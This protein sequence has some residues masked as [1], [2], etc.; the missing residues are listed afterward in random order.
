MKK[1]SA[2]IPAPITRPGPKVVPLQHVQAAG[3]RGIEDFI[4]ELGPRNQVR[5]ELGI[6]HPTLLKRLQSPGTFTADEIYRLAHI[7]GSPATAILALLLP[8]LRLAT[9]QKSEEIN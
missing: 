1:K 4:R 2:E 3:C 7:S 9:E 8:E 5:K 6:S